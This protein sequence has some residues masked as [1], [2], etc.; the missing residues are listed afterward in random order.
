V[1]RLYRD[2]RLNPIHEGAHGIHGLDLLGRKVV[3]HDGAA[4]KELMQRIRKDIRS[5]A[6]IESLSTLAATLETHLCGVEETTRLLTERLKTDARLALA[7]ASIFLDMLGHVVIGWMWL[8]QATT[9]SRLLESGQ[10]AP[11]FLH[12]K[13]GACRYFFSHTLPHTSTQRTLLNEMD[14]TTLDMRPEW[15]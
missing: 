3:Q 11:E 15:F 6:S 10:G 13:I 5:A 4:F 9:A 2:N 12:G 14:S 8:R 1:E 7:N